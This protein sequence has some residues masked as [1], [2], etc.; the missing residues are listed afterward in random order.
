MIKQDQ[1]ETASSDFR[2]FD[3]ADNM[4]SM[5]VNDS[6]QIMENDMAQSVSCVYIFIAFFFFVFC[7][8]GGCGSTDEN[9]SSAYVLCGGC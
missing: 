8:D 9:V 3:G 1:N 4:Y 5:Y 2:S 7:V 6:K